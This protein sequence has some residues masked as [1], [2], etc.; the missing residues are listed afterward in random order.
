MAARFGSIVLAALL[1]F[2]LQN[3]WSS[4]PVDAFYE[5]ESSDGRR[6]VEAVGSLRLTGAYLDS[7]DL[8]VLYANEKDWLA[9][10]VGRLI[11]DGDLGSGID[12]E[13]NAFLELSRLPP[14]SLY[15]TYATAGS[16]RSPYRTPYLTWDFWEEGEG[17]GQLGLD[18]FFAT[19]HAP[20]VDISLGRMPI[21]FSVM[22]L[23][24]P[25]DFFAPFSA[26]AINKVYKPGVDAL[27]VSLATGSLG[28]L[29]VVGA[30]GSDEDGEPAL[31]RCSLVGR[32]SLVRW[33]FQWAVVGGR[34]AGRSVVGGSLQG[35]LGR[36]G[37]RSE[38]HVGF[39][40]P[41]ATGTFRDASA[42]V[43]I[44]A[45]LDVPFSWRNAVVGA[46]YLFLS[47]GAEGPAGYLLRAAS[48]F[49]DDLVYLGR[50]YV[51]MNAGGEILPILRMNLMGL[52][53]A[54]DG[55]GLA[56]LMLLWNVLDEADLV[57]G[58]LV[59]WGAGPSTGPAPG[60]PPVINSEFGLMPI[61]AFLETRIYF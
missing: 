4:S 46:D 32:A 26:T 52:I 34:L 9:A 41:S 61:T 51:G 18:R 29:E 3:L 10:G 12:F 38:G 23:F 60:T 1:L 11:L 31:D 56:A 33:S 45:G 22:N 8:P 40:D 14:L 19:L 30:L 43:R 47:D 37:I 58:V 57:A 5:A 15:G 24:T 13:C 20:P 16:V 49:P 48:L 50:H 6:S 21:N 35:D 55:S 59:P 27:R 25:N 39:P 53:N 44:A 2:I 17:T 36:V 28:S 7:P 54:G 42:Y